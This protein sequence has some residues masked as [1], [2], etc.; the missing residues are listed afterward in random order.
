MSEWIIERFA[1]F[2]RR[3]FLAQGEI[4]Y[5][6]SELAEA[7]SDHSTYFAKQGIRAGDTV[8]LETDYSFS[9]IAALFALFKLKAIVAPVTTVSDSELKSR[10]TEVNARWNIRPDS[11]TEAFSEK[12]FVLVSF[13]L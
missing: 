7:I 5:T 13:C 6:Y 11:K 8:T 4:I 12:R 9:A 2:A 1:G 10:R 3:P